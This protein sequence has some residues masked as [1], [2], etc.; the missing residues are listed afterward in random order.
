[1]LLIH[2]HTH[3]IKLKFTPEELV[4]HSRIAREYQRQSTIVHNQLQKDMTDKIWMQQEAMRSL[5]EHLRAAA[6]IC[7][8][9]PPPEDRP[10]PIWDTPPIAGFNPQDYLDDGK[11]A[12]DEF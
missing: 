8:E 6:L 10:W 5:P 12:D 4:E 7:D 9:T 11:K 1:M 2:T 3:R